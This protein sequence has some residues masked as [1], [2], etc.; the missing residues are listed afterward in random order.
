MKEPA[1]KAELKIVKNNAK[2]GVLVGNKY[3]FGAP[4]RGVKDF[5]LL[6]ISLKI[7]KNGIAS[8]TTASGLKK[9]EIIFNGHFNFLYGTHGEGQR[10]GKM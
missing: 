8:A 6:G 1:P 2:T 4:F 10:D 3:P 9:A 7:V 5:Y